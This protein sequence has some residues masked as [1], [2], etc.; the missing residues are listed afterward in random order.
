MEL[1]FAFAT[2]FEITFNAQDRQ[3]F[4]LICLLTRTFSISLLSQLIEETE[5]TELRDLCVSQSQR[6]FF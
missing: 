3:V 4:H 2:S 6:N 5:L 1:R